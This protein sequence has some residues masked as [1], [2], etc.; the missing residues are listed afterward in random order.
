MSPTKIALVTG[1]TR[2]IGLAI[3]EALTEDY[4]VIV[5]GRRRERTLMVANALDAIPFVVDLTDPAAIS[6]GVQEVCEPLGRLDL[7]V[8][9]AGVATWQPLAQSTPD[10]WVETFAANV[11]GPA[12]LTRALLPLLLHSGGQVININSGAGLRAG[13]NYGVYSASKFALTAFTDTLREELG[14]KIRV[15]SVHPGRVST[16]MQR[17]LEGEGGS[18][19]TRGPE[20][21][22]DT[23]AQAV[24]LAARMP[25]G[26]SIDQISIRPTP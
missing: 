11:F 10:L 23:V 22:P 2:G 6:A 18:R 5:G 19:Y 14:D 3:A 15:T 12:E 9:N 26:A 8:N 1:A 21:N 4:R 20:L 7:L 25:A 13:A 17:Q 16:Q 24:L